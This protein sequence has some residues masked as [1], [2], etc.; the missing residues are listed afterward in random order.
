MPQM[1][2]IIKMLGKTNNK[3]GISNEKYGND[4]KETGQTGD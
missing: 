2:I 4:G 1:C 3:Q